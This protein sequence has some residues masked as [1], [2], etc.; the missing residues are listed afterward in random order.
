MD[1]F[2]AKGSIYGTKDAGR[3]W[4]KKL[5][6]TVQE[7]GWQMSKYEAALFYLFE[8]NKLIGVMASHVDDL[9]CTGTGNK[10]ESTIKELEVKLYLKV[11]KNDFR[12]CG[13]NVKATSNSIDLDQYDAIE[14]IEYVVVDKERRNAKRLIDRPTSGA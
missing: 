2:R 9:F 6:K 11:H 3:S 5:F 10:F 4:W 7:H 8:E 12:F 14:G 1:L 13:K